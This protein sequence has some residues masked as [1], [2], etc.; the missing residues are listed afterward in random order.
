MATL[1]LARSSG[2]GRFERLFAVKVTH[3]HLSKDRVFV[4][5]FLNE[6]RIAAKIQ[7]PNVIPV[8]EIDVEAGRYYMVM[9]YVSGETLALALKNTWNRDKPFP[10]AYAAQIVAS[11][12]E[13]LHAAHEL[14]GPDGA[15]AV[16][17]RDVAPQ[18][19]MLGYDGIVR[20]MDFGIAK[21]RD[22]ISTTKPGVM[23]GTIAYMAPEQVRCQTIDRRVDI[24]A[25]G[26]I[27]WEAT[28]GMRLFRHKNDVTTAARVV[29]MQVP[30]PST[31]RSGY[32]PE[33][34]R[35]VMKALQRDPE[36]R[37]QTTRAMGEE[38]SEYLHAAKERVTSAVLAD[39]MEEVFRERLPHRR[40]METRAREDDPPAD[41]VM[42]TSDVSGASLGVVNE[43]EEVDLEDLEGPIS[44]SEPL[45]PKE[46]EREPAPAAEATVTTGGLRSPSSQWS[47]QT[48]VVRER[49]TS[50]VPAPIDVT[51]RVTVSLPEE[52]VPHPKSGKTPLL[53]GA[54]C[55]AGVLAVAVVLATDSSSRPTAAEADTPPPVTGAP[56]RK[57]EA[58][59]EPPPVVEEVTLRFEVTPS[60]AALVAN[61]DPVEGT[62]VLPKSDEQ[63]VVRAS[64]PG[65]RTAT[66][67]VGAEADQTVQVTLDPLRT[68]RKRARPRRVKQYRKKRLEKKLKKKPRLLFSS[69]DI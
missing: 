38:L 60:G 45:D 10:L 43:H 32:P 52:G 8:Y 14:D 47:L 21:A 36:Q 46:F 31:L 16:V 13:G 28:V 62:L 35:I 29:K 23:K 18:N 58:A 61:G 4:E 57:T 67:I 2:V 17:H 9:D 69:D 56:K 66:V 7:H 37:Y 19:L 20:V 11:A 15:L 33:L 53:V 22:T 27:L 65:H 25:L 42:P 63:V 30:P 12:C 59:P 54:V 34:E 24:F 51:R 64:A 39:F 68:P 49:S 48:M 55:V 3:D 50:Q 26:T 41:L 6:A 40:E 1:Y 44:F 5:M